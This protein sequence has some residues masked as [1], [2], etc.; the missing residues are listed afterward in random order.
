MHKDN[1]SDV[2]NQILKLFIESLC[3][4]DNNFSIFALCMRV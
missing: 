4:L 1:T 3:G 2:A